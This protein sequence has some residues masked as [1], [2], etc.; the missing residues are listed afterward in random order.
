MKHKIS[1]EMRAND[2]YPDFI[3]ELEDT[4]EYLKEQNCIF[5]AAILSNN[6]NHADLERVDINETIKDL[7]E[8][9]RV[10]NIDNEALIKSK[11]MF[12]ERCDE[13]YIQLA[14]WQKRIK[15]NPHSEG[16]SK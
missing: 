10:L 1:K 3:R 16:V 11:A 4:I 15:Q 14:Y 6:F 7:N 9:I 2:L 13:A 8:L 5:E 12:A